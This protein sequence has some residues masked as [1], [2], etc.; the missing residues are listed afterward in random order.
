MGTTSRLCVQIG[1][2]HEPHCERRS[3]GILYNTGF[4]RRQLLNFYEMHH[5]RRSHDPRIGLLSCV[6]DPS[7]H[8]FPA[9]FVSFGMRKQSPIGSMLHTLSPSDM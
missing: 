9:E 2:H 8:L 5:G 7:H 3:N 1:T 6:S 4:V